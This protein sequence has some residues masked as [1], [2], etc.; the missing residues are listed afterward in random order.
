MKVMDVVKGRRIAALDFTKGALVLIMVLYHWLNYFAR[1]DL[2]Y[3]YLRFLPPSFIF[4]TGFLISHLYLAGRTVD[5]SVS[6]RLLT[7]AVKLVMVFGVL[8]V[9]RALVIGA[10]STGTAATDR[11]TVTNILSV[12][13]VGPDVADKVM[14]F[15][16]L[17]PISYLLALSAA[18]L[19]CYRS[20]RYVFQLTCALLLGAVAVFSFVGLHSQNLEFV[21]IGMLGVLAGLIPI[22]KISRVAGH[23]YVLA[24]L[25]VGYVLAITQWNTPFALLV[26]GVCLTLLVLYQM[27][28]GDAEGDRLRRHVCLLGKYSLFGYVAQ[29]AI[30]QVMSAGFRHLGAGQAALVLSFVLAFASTMIAVELVDR[31][32]ARS[33]IVNRLYRAAF[34]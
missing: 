8:N 12:F 17:I 19:Q 34:A 26:P 21:T 29:I 32:K 33:I 2:D 22:D 14:S 18:L 20:F 16:I 25:Y 27:G 3:R 23:Y 9:A 31:V 11:L 30:L 28:S 4:I 10:L 5:L 7:R 24:L 1:P 15:Y 6:K 13:L